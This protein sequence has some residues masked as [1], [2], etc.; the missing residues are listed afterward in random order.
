MKNLLLLIALSVCMILGCQTTKKDTKPKIVYKKVEKGPKVSSENLIR[1]AF[2][3]PVIAV[4]DIRAK[5]LDD[6]FAVEQ[7]KIIKE[8]AKNSTNNISITFLSSSGE[9]QVIHGTIKVLDYKMDRTELSDRDKAILISPQSDLAY[10][11]IWAN[12]YGRIVAS[13]VVAEDSEEPGAELVQIVLGSRKKK[14]VE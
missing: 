1:I 9:E 2:E 5:K 12:G 11:E 10:E 4:D 14:V 13:E 6:P 8:Y 7:E 3:S